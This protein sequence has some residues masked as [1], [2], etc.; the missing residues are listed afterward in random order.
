ML[1]KSAKL[2]IRNKQ[3]MRAFGSAG[4][5]PKVEAPN[6]LQPVTIHDA[7]HHDHHHDVHKPSLDHKFLK[8]IA[9]PKMLFFDG[10]HGTKNEVR[11]LDN[12]FA[13][14]NN[15]PMLQ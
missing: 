9:N 15:L 2:F 14:L 12:H 1:N 6:G 4:H 11:S 10:L 7:H 5:G 8:P 13:H 3:L